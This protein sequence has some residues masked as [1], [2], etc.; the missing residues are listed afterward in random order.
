MKPLDSD[1]RRRRPALQVAVLVVALTA[2]V[3]IPWSLAG[4]VPGDSYRDEFLA[5]TFTGNDG[6]LTWATDW[7]ELG[8]ADGP[9]DGDIKVDSSGQCLDDICL[10]IG[11]DGNTSTVSVEREA[12]LTE[13]AAATLYFSFR[14]HR[15]GNPAAQ[16][17]L[18]VSDDGGGSWTP[19]NSWSLAIEEGA[20]VDAS[21]DLT[22]YIS[23]NTRIRFRLTG[24]SDGTHMNIDDIAI[25]LDD[26]WYLKGDGVPQASLGAAPVQT[27]LP[28][29]DPAHDAEDG[30]LLEKTSAGL[31][32]ETDPNKHQWWVSPAGYQQIGGPVRLT[33]W[34]ALAGFDPAGRGVVDAGL[35]DCLPDGTD[36]N[37][38]TTANLDLVSWAGGSGTWVE[39]E[40][41]FGSVTATIAAGR[42]LAVKLVVASTASGDMLF[43][44]DTTGYPS[45]LAVTLVPPDNKAPIFDQDLGDR[46]D[47]ENTVIS[48]SSAAT[49]P[50]A[51]NLIYSATGL[52][53]GLT[54]APGTGLITG[55]I[56]YTAATDSP[57]SVQIVVT[58]NGTPARTDVDSFTWTVTNVNRAPDFDQDI[59]NRTDPEGTV[60]SVSAAATDPDADNLTYGATNL[61]PGLTIDTDTGLISGT[62]DYS[63]AGTYSTEITVAD[64]GTPVKSATPDTFTWTV[65][66]TN[67]PPTISNP[68]N[69]STPELSP[70]LATLTASDP[71]GA[72]P[73]FSHGGTLPAWAT[74]TDNLDGTATISGTPGPFDA[75]RTTVTITASDG[76]VPNLS[77]GAT[78]DITVTNTNQP[79]TINPVTDRTVGEGTPLVPIT[80][81]ASDPDLTFPSIAAAG[82]P[83]WASIIDHGDGT[84]TI[85]GT[86]GYSDAA[87]SKVTITAHDNGSPDL[88]AST[89]FNLT[90]T[91]TNRSPQIAPID[92]IATDEESEI[93][94]KVAAS[95]VDSDA[96]SFRLADGADPVPVGATI[97]A[98]G[99]FTWTPT[100]AQGPG[101]YTFA[102]AATDN[103]TPALT[104]QQLITVTVY[105]VNRPPVL[106]AASQQTVTEGTTLRYELSASDEDL[107]ANG[108]R[109][110]L[111][112]A[113]DGVRIGAHTG[114]MTWT[115]TAAQAP[116]TF[117][118]KIVATDDGDPKLTATETVTIEVRARRTVS[119]PPLAPPDPE[120]PATEEPPPP[121]EPLPAEPEPTIDDPGP[122]TEEIASQARKNDVV[123]TVT[124]RPEPTIAH[125]SNQIRRTLVLMSRAMFTTVSA[126]GAPL[127]LLVAMIGAVALFGRITIAS[128]FKKSPHG[129]G[130]VGW[131]DS[132]RGFGFIIPDDAKADD[133]QLFVH[134]SHIRR[135]HRGNLS[136]ND[137]VAFRIVSGPRRSFARAVVRKSTT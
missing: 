28:N 87:N 58:D 26:S 50:D 75:A 51:D 43:A 8:E 16:V 42:S 54:I 122:T 126:M 10:I 108:L 45:R 36:C 55:T 130:K 128:P 17:E 70:F 115:P 27:V 120:P 3:A 63:A 83:T 133:E 95:D 101:S 100:E 23:S 41:N 60:I 86:P 29:Y 31:A 62:I 109:F 124:A 76:G 66:D 5:K 13:G 137:R 97:T 25:V 113:P 1:H 9:N 136:V 19:L 57:H 107:P 131:Y 77:A 73:S 33:L 74:L 15:H 129:T 71:D 52:P 46:T 11:E 44:Y 94:F 69:K 96:T 2:A 91:S 49:D 68:G 92:N 118:F 14:R 64:D 82:L 89:S 105:E 80:V 35:Y 119:A 61:P 59:L 135:A 99:V 56:D 134:S 37:L 111:E 22:P 4:A 78:F 30:R 117:V 88:T 38:I 72:T 114:V 67:R 24:D 110:S 12:D 79:P 112:G 104:A 21:F 47:P 40:V 81:T 6:T 93:S 116:G 102:I 85:S 20:P 7:L 127:W 90:V 132:T 32:A 53:P 121:E 18:A 125:E 65:T 123:S 106:A 103:G 34:S 84:A 98:D 39:R 48:I